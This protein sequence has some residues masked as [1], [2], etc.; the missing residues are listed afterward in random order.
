MR[1]LLNFDFTFD[2]GHVKFVLPSSAQPQ[3]AEFFVWRGRLVSILA[4][5]GWMNLNL[6]SEFKSRF[7]NF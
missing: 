5:L 2:L 6:K 3:K 1:Q 4:V 7:F